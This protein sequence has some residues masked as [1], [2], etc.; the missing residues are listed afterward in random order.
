[1]KK[2]VNWEYW[3]KGYIMTDPLFVF[4]SLEILF[5]RQFVWENGEKRKEGDIDGPDDNDTP[6]CGQDTVETAREAEKD[7]ESFLE[8]E[9]EDKSEGEAGV[10]DDDD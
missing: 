9:C 4:R 8:E 7:E 5:T 1:M 10:S 6:L 2:I 3:G